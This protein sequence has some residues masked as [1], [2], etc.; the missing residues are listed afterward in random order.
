MQILL[1][2]LTTNFNNVDWLPTPIHYG[3]GDIW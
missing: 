1:L 3:V 2:I